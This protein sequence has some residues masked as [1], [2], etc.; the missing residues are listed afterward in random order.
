MHDGLTGS[1]CIRFNSS[2]MAVSVFSMAKLVGR[3]GMLF[4][5]LYFGQLDFCALLGC[6]LSSSAGRESLSICCGD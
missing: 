3:V 4:N 2:N 1:I 5:I 6:Q